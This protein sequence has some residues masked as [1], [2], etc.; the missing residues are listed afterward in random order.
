M[1]FSRKRDAL[2]FG[3]GSH[4]EIQWHRNCLGQCRHIRVGYVTAIFAQVG[5]YSIRPSSL[6]HKGRARWIRV[7]ATACIA[8]SSN[9][10]DVHA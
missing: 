8:H 9:V 5:R 4:F 7:I 3:S 2:H 6:R 1:R 10:V